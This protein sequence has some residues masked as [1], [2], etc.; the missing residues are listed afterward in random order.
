MVTRA[1]TSGSYS[2]YLPFI[3]TSPMRVLWTDDCDPRTDPQFCHISASLTILNEFYAALNDVGATIQ[4]AMPQSL[5]QLKQ[6]DV[7][8]A[9]YCSGLYR[10]NQSPLLSEYVAQGGSVIVLGDNFC[11]VGSD[12]Q[13]NVSSARA[14]NALTMSRGITFTLDDVSDIQFSNQIHVHPTTA[15]VNTIYSYRHAYLQVNS[16]ATPVVIMASKPFIAVYDGTGTLIAIPNIGFHWGNSF[17]RAGESDN[18]VFWRNA[19]RWTV[20]QSHLKQINRSIILSK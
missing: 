20:L 10:N 5:D 12:S 19:L 3:A 9:D 14:A 17:Q 6:Y 16:S 4:Y 18:F 8:I 2:I 15:N 13:G 11:I 7:V 1:Q